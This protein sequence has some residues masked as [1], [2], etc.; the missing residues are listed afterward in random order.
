MQNNDYSPESSI[1]I[2][3]PT[4]EQPETRSP[5]SG[6]A[7]STDRSNRLI[8]DGFD[9]IQ[10]YVGNAFQTMRFLCTTFGFDP[11]A[12]SGLETGCRDHVSYAVKQG[13]IRILITSV[14]DPT[15]SIGEEVKIHGDA[16]KE[17][18][19]TVPD[20]AEAFHLALS[21]GAIGVADPSTSEDECGHASV[22][23]IRAFGN[24]IHTFV[25]RK[26]YT[27]S[28]LPGYRQLSPGNRNRPS[29]LLDLDHV[30]LSVPTGQLDPMTEFYTQ[31]L[32]METGH[33]ENIVTAYSAMNSRVVQN[34]SGTVRF[35]M[36]EPGASRRTS[37]I[38]EFLKYNHGPGIQHL[39]FSSHN[40]VEVVRAFQAAG[41]EFL[42]TPAAYYDLLDARVGSISENTTELRD[43]N[44]LVDRDEWGYLLQIFSKPITAR[45]TLFLE[46]IQRAGAR[47][48]G[49]GNIRALFDAVEREQALRGNL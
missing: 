42:K 45:P 20:A 40:I 46:L 22:A 16:V 18:A 24:V 49:S 12:Y 29:L 27:G 5:E 35:P 34:C 33:V 23:T 17:I 13:N 44:V 28:F 31:T 36:M 37:Q 9:Y 8:L 32:S 41:A 19:F 14:L 25:E 3:E 6:T 26:E 7:P 48:F 10:L 39:A 15:N 21:R 1:L 30:A 38:E 11:V 43:C 4:T 47:G 2:S